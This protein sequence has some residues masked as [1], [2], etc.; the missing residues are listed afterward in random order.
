MYEPH[1]PKQLYKDE[2]KKCLRL[3]E[4]THAAMWDLLIILETDR[5]EYKENEDKEA[6]EIYDKEYD[7]VEEPTNNLSYFLDE[8][9]KVFM[10]Y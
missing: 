5:D 2:Y 6:F 4:E 9:R 10:T 3:L 7:L 1:M 8:Y